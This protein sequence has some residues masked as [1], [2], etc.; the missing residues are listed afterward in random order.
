MVAPWSRWNV[1][2]LRLHVVCV[3]VNPGVRG[4]AT[5][6]Q[7]EETFGGWDRGTIY[8]QP[9]LFV[10]LARVCWPQ[11]ARSHLTHQMSKHCRYYYDRLTCLH[12]D[13]YSIPTDLS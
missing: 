8:R 12:L 3:V 9:G 1:Y 7:K 10:S 2:L 11:I 13:S 6:T 5:E 4:A